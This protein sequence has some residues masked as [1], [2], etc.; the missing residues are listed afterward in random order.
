MDDDNHNV[1]R[2]LPCHPIQI[3]YASLESDLEDLGL[4]TSTRWNKG[5][6]R[7]RNSSISGWAKYF[8]LCRSRETIDNRFEHG[9][10]DNLDET[11]KAPTSE[12]PV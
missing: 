2:G 1:D 11:E 12:H 7:F 4:K 5:P 8:I 3:K 9:S 6:T 10:Q